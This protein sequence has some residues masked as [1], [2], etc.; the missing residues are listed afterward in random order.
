M[1]VHSI[2]NDRSAEDP[3]HP[4]EASALI[5]IACYAYS[6]GK[7]D[8][9]REYLGRFERT[10]VQISHSADWIQGYLH[11]TQARTPARL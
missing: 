1:G 5:R 10:G 4:A 3:R 9:A 7:H 11:W 2:S 6:A 8:L